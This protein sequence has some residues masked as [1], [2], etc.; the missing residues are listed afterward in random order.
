MATHLPE[1]VMTKIRSGSSVP[2][3]LSGST[4]HD[5][6]LKCP[7]YPTGKLPGSSPIGGHCSK[8]GLSEGNFPQHFKGFTPKPTPLRVS[9]ASDPPPP[10]GRHHT[11]KTVSGQAGQH[12]GLTISKDDESAS[13]ELGALVVLRQPHKNIGNLC[14]QQN[15]VGPV[16]PANETERKP[17]PQGGSAHPDTQRCSL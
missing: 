9:A 10:E 6:L 15:L 4:F 8:N 17:T 3:N 16:Q 13:T 5:F 2:P 7:A 14:S 1:T 12:Q 11:W